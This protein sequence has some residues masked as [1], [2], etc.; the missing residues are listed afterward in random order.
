MY[1]VTFTEDTDFVQLNWISYI[2]ILS[3]ILP[4]SYSI[5]QTNNLS[6]DISLWL[7]G[8]KKKVCRRRN[9]EKTNA[10]CIF[11]FLFFCFF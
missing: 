7:L 4:L 2:K 6:Q 8:K 3:D 5:F 9:L 10:K 1:G 11:C